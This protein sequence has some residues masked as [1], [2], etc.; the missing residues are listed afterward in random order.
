MSESSL[1]DDVKHAIP[2]VQGKCGVDIY[3]WGDFLREKD[4][5]HNSLAACVEI[6]NFYKDEDN[7]TP[8]GAL[9]KYK[10]IVKNHWI[11]S[12]VLRVKHEMNKYQYLLVE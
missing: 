9:N 3:V 8:R 7:R 4:I 5:D 11:T 10:G 1:R 12:K 2:R 6:F